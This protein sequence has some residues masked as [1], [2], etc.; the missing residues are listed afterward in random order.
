[1]CDGQQTVAQIMDRLTDEIR[2]TPQSAQTHV[3]EAL[4]EKARSQGLIAVYRT[5][6]I[7]EESYTGAPSIP[8]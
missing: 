1:L 6:S 8:V 2:V 5:T 3:Y 4:L 7:A